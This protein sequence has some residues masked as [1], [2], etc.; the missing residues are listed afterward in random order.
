MTQNSFE[1]LEERTKFYRRFNA[2]GTQLKVRLAPPPP[3][4]LDSTQSPNPVQHFL[5]SMNQL[6]E[7]ALKIPIQVTW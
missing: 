3:P 2:R 7:Y 5:D 6:I 1:V 4:P